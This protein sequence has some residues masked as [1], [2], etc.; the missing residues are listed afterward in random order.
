MKYREAEDYTIFQ[1]QR[2]LEGIE[3]FV[4]QAEKQCE[5][6]RFSDAADIFDNPER[7]RER[8]RKMLGFPLIDL[9]LKAA[10]LI[11]KEK[12]SDEDGYSIYRLSF[13]ILDDIMMSGLLFKHN[14]EK[15]PMAIVQH[16][17]L[18]TPE[19]ISGIYGRENNYNNMLMRIFRQGVN[20]FAPQ[21]LLW[22]PEDCGVK[23]ERQITDSR[24]QRVGSSI[25]A[26]E[27][28]GIISIISYFEI[29][30]YVSRFGMLGLS[31]GGF[32]T[33]LTAALDTRI[34][35]ALSCSWFNKREKNCIFTDWAWSNAANILSDAEVACLIYPRQL[36]IE[37]GS[38]D[39]FFCVDGAYE[40]AER[41]K[42]YCE[43]VGC[44]W[45]DFIVFDGMHEF[46]EDDAPLKKFVTVL[47]ND[48]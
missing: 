7:H 44:N 21:L 2:Y 33:V 28:Y 39:E 12:L 22:K 43:K 27:I 18:G 13:E 16:G 46:C 48:F 24:L 37:V 1:R 3:K 9:D 40:E 19:S 30:A 42:K 45:Y 8:L 26:I 32:Y 23:Y 17:G 4:C 25:T 36:C 35:A 31:Y 5:E 47:K 38:R 29:Q 10:K 6:K 15:L 14:E 41:L 34:K 20:V 11:H